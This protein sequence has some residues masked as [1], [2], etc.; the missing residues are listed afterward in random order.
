MKKLQITV[1]LVICLTLTSYSQETKKHETTYRVGPAL[2][3]VWEEQRTGIYGEFTSK[4]FKIEK[5][6][7]KEN[8]W[9][10]TNI[11]D[12]TE[13]LQLRAAIG[14]ALSEEGVIIE[15]KMEVRK[16]LKGI[17]KKNQ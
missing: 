2:V 17:E 13:L 5:L 1:L 8:E 14:K 4:S 3:T 15:E 6:Y 12:L 9:K 10:R 7:K 11:F 16:N